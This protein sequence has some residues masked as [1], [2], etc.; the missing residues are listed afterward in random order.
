MGWNTCKILFGHSS[1]VFD[2]RWSNDSKYL[3][4]GSIDNSA[5]LWNV[6]KGIKK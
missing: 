2:I 5:I 1:D 3:I 6:E 4:S